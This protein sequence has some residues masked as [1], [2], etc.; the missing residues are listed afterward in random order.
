M[1]EIFSFFFELL[2]FLVFFFVENMIVFGLFEFDSGVVM[3]ME[4][5][6]LYYDFFISDDDEV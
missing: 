2:S 1:L 3:D 4:Y 5:Y 6:Y